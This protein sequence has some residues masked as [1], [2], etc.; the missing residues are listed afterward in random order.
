MTNEGAVTL[1][2]EFS[3]KVVQVQGPYHGSSKVL[4]S[5]VTDLKVTSNC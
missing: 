5:E 2:T 4:F 3:I 1:V